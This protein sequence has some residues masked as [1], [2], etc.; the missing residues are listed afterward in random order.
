MKITK[1]D[2]LLPTSF[3]CS[4]CNLPLC[5]P[6]CEGGP[7]HEPECL[8]LRRAQPR[9]TVTEQDS[10]NPVYSAVATIR[11]LSGMKTRPDIW[12]SGRCWTS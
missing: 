2:Y 8:V 7:V 6:Q 1:L 12:D 3:Q 5:G 4:L 11:M 10:F 9:L